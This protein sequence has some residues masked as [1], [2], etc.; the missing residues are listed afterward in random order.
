M[1]PLLNL[2]DLDL[3]KVPEP[4]HIQ[5][6]APNKNKPLVPETTTKANL[7]ARDAF[8]QKV[9]QFVFSSRPK[10]NLDRVYM[11]N[12]ETYSGAKR[13]IEFDKKD[14]PLSKLPTSGT[15]TPSFDQCFFSYSLK[16][17]EKIESVAEKAARS[18][19]YVAQTKVFINHHPCE[20]E[21]LKIITVCSNHFKI[22]SDAFYIPT[23]PWN[24]PIYV[25]AYVIKTR[26]EETVTWVDLSKIFNL[27]KRSLQDGIRGA[28]KRKKASWIKDNEKITAELNR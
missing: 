25:A 27:N 3:L 14:L 1:N 18:P 24:Y 5:A 17:E 16:S 4:T 2:V 23:H 13:K 11:E 28:R 26:L 21:I 10:Y 20:K 15:D 19:D 12:P 6:L 22:V 7:S 8:S 9:G